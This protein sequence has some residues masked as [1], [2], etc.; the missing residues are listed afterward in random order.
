METKDFIQIGIGLILTLIGAYLKM[1]M[2]SIEKQIDDNSN[3]IKER[4]ER[5]H[6]EHKEIYEKINTMKDSIT[7]NTT[8]IEHCKFCQGDVE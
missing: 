7:K 4:E 6:I 8:T 2:S 3:M 5:N 1:A